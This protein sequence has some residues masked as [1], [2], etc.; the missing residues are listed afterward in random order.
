MKA[1]AQAATFGQVVPSPLEQ[2]F[3]DKGVKR[4]ID[5]AL[6]LMSAVI[7]V[8][9]IAVMA[10]LV[11]LDGHAP[12]YTQKRIGRNGRVFRIVKMR[13]MV[14]NADALLK[15][16]L[17]KNPELQAEWDATQ[18]LKHDIRITR[19]GRFLRKTSMDELPQL[20][21]VLTGSM[22]LVG[23]RPMMVSQQTLY[24]GQSYYRMR[25]GVTGFWQVSDRNNCSFRDRAKFDA[26]YEQ[27]MS[28]STDARVLA[29]TVS[30][31]LRGTG[32]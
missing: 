8:P 17:S 32:Y 24:P 28:F 11:A 21:N 22:S 7:V 20:I 10:L 12:F 3:Y 29:Q 13:T 2:P 16:H 30:V 15:E 27:A 31:V 14:H 19:I 26:K 18:K 4:F 5:V 6:V 23:P 25:P 1:G 9:L